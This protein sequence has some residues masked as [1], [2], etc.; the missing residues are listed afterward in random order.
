MIFLKAQIIVNEKKSLK[1]YTLYFACV[2]VS[3]CVCVCT[4]SMQNFKIHKIVSQN[5]IVSDSEELGET[6]K[7]FQ[8][9]QF[10]DN[11]SNND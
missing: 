10:F 4:G 2:S 6:L 3:V 11:S 7:A 9:K 5:H 8:Q 1:S